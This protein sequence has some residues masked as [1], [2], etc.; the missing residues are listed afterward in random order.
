MSRCWP[1]LAGLLC[2][3]KKVI[4]W[5]PNVSQD[6]VD[7]KFREQIDWQKAKS[8]S[9]WLLLWLISISLVYEVAF[10]GLVEPLS[11]SH[12]SA[13]FELLLRNGKCDR[14]LNR[15]YLSA[16]TT[17]SYSLSAFLLVAVAV[18]FSGQQR[19]KS[20]DEGEPNPSGGSGPD[21]DPDGGDYPFFFEFLNPLHEEEAEGSEGEN[22]LKEYELIRGSGQ[23]HGASGGSNSPN[24]NGDNNDGGGNGDDK[25]RRD[26]NRRLQRALAYSI[27]A[28]LLGVLITTLLPLPVLFV[29]DLPPLVSSIISSMSNIVYTFLTHAFTFI[30]L[31]MVW[32]SVELVGLLDTSSDTD[33]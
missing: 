10:C 21:D 1:P 22:R 14:L 27:S 33:K 28:S 6:E 13:L 32:T 7:L 25:E 23:L 19:T 18:V 24:S 2:L 15:H 9:M 29:Y 26:F 4:N 8:G 5:F 3:L 17:F 31:G 20:D 11:I 12:D 16:A 30:F